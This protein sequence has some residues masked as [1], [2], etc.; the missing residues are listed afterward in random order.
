MPDTVFVTGFPGFL[1]SRLL[2]RIL[3]RSPDARAACLVQA[4]FEGLAKERVQAL[5]AAEPGLAARIDLMTGDLT[6]RDLGLEDSAALGAGVTEIWH[7]AAVYDLSVP[8]DVGLR[9]NVD[10]T[11]NVLR[12][13]EGCPGLRRHHYVSTCYVSGRYCGPFRETDLDRGQEFNNHYEETKFLA[14][15]EVAGARDGGMP[16]TVYRPAIVVGDS[17]TGD[18]QKFDGPYFLL[19][20]LLR[21]PER[22]AL[23]PLVGDPT[24]VRFNMVPSDFVIDAIDHLSGLDTS[25]GRTYQLADPRPLTVDALLDA[26]CR[27]VGRRG[28]RVPLPRRLT[29]WA[30]ANIEPL[31]RYVGIPAS[32][33]DYFVHPTHYDTSGTDRDLAGSGVACPAVPDYLPALVR[34]MTE[35]RE[36]NVGVMI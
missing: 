25:L 15:V 21:Q 18:T 7:L 20:W 14:E 29:T 1:G 6:A 12:F 17:R 23:V 16:T 28:I 24:M 22:W 27:A 8:R 33:V 26:M 35:H 19:Q 11:R 2:P 31:E 5:D 4:K 10:G 13:A 3:R 34:F 36:A 30:L 32:A 9:V